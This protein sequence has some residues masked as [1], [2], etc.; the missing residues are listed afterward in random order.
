MCAQILHDTKYFRSG[1]A[2]YTPAEV[3]SAKARYAR[4]TLKK[5]R[6]KQMD[7]DYIL[8]PGL[9]IRGSRLFFTSRQVE[10]AKRRYIT[11]KSSQLRVKQ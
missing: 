4:E 10:S 3:A 9:V 8:P 5:Q 2:L 6:A 1:D 7:R 11:K